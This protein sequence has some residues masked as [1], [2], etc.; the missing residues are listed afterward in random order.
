M[1]PD[2][3]PQRD[4]FV[5]GIV[6]SNL[7]GR[8]DALMDSLYRNGVD[9]ANMYGP[10]SETVDAELRAISGAGNRPGAS[11]SDELAAYLVDWYY[12]EDDDMVQFCIDSYRP[13]RAG[14]GAPSGSASKSRKSGVSAKPARASTGKGAARRKP[15]RRR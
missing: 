15:A 9:P 14:G 5:Q 3:F 11:L 13:G 2:Y 8:I 7:R 1:L 10:V 4:G 6:Y 12:D